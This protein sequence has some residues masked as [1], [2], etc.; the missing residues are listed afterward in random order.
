M[1]LL[2]LSL[3]PALNLI[4]THSQK[5]VSGLLDKYNKSFSITVREDPDS[6]KHIRQEA[7]EQFYELGDCGDEKASK[8]KKKERSPIKL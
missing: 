2:S 7:K 1:T 6:G 4:H 5:P 3:L 8:K